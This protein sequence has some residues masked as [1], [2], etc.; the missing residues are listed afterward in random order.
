[1][2]VCCSVTL[3]L[4]PNIHLKSFKTKSHENPSQAPWKPNKSHKI[5]TSFAPAPTF[6]LRRRSNFT[7]SAKACPEGPPRIF[8]EMLKT[9]LEFQSL[10]Q[11]AQENTESFYV[12]FGDISDISQWIGFGWCLK[13]FK[14]YETP[15][16][17]HESHKKW[18]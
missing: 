15:M 13:M 5:P 17:H 3:V 14:A 7:T 9:S 4:I 6:N 12:I 8:G 2:Q 11:M 18:W 16:N 10:K 1:M